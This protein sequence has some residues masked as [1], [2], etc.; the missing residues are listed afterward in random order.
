[1]TVLFGSIF[2]ITA[3]SARTAAL[4]AGLV[5]VAVLA[6]ARP[7]LFASIDEAVAAAR[8]VPVKLLGFAF[9]ALVGTTA[10]E[11]TQAVGALLL[12]GLV[13]APAGA[14]TLLTDRPYRALALSGSLAVAAMWIGLT[15]SYLVPRIPPSFAI[16]ATATLFYIA[17][18]AVTR[19]R[20][21]AL[22]THRQPAPSVPVTVG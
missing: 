11:A 14:A 17:A 19:L 16:T 6:I 18:F 4:I 9:L 5:I 3:G 8:G 10:A 1:V 22:D 21:Q 2:G 15:V 13:A 20:R 7:L 12:L